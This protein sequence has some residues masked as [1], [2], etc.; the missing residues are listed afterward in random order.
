MSRS[1]K[2]SVP[3]QKY[4]ADKRNR[5]GA[6][7]IVNERIHESLERK[8]SALD[9][10][11]LGIESLPADIARLVHLEKLD[12]S[13]NRLAELPASIGQLTRLRRLDLINNRLAVVPESIGRLS[14]LERLYL[15]YN[16]LAV[17][18]ESIGRLTKLQN[19]YL[20]GNQLAKVPE[21][22]GQLSGLQR[23]SLGGNR[24]TEVPEWFGQL[25]ELQVLILH[26][27]QLTE[28][29]EWF[30][31]LA[32]LQELILG[33]NQLAALPKSIGQLAGLRVLEV[34][35]NQLASLPEE[36]RRL[37]RL[38]A[39]YLHDNPAVAGLPAEVLGPTWRQVLHDKKTPAKPDQILDY[40]FRTR[41]PVRPLNE[42]KLILLGRG[43]VGK[44]CLV[45][46]LVHDTFEPQP[47][48]EGIRIT[49]WPVQLYGDEEVRLHVWDF[50]GQEIMHA[51][52]QFFLTERSLY[53]L[54]LSGREGT[55]DLDAEYWLRIIESFG[56]ES[57]V[58]VVLNKI[59]VKPFDV[60]RRALQSKYPGIREFLLTDCN[61]RTG[62]D[63]LHAAIRREI[64]RLEDRRAKIPATWFA[65]K[66]GLS[67]TG[68]NYLTY[69]EYRK[70]CLERGET[71]PDAQDK[72]AGFLHVLGIA[73]NYRDDPRLRYHHV[74]NPHWVTAGIYALINSRLLATQ[75]G[76][77][78][79]DDIARIV[80]S[81]AAAG[82]L[83]REDYPRSMHGFLLD[84]MR[85]F[86]LCFPFPGDYSRYLVPELLDKQEP[87]EAAEFD[88]A[89]CLNFQYHYPVV[90]EGL[91]PRFTVRT[92][93]LSEG[94]PRWR[95]GVILQFEGNL[96]L[97]KADSAE[98]RVAI[99]VRGPSP[100]SRRRLLAVIRSDFD[101]IHRD[102]KRKPQE[103]VP[104]PKLPDVVV[105]YKNL[106]AFEEK[107]ISDLP[108]VAGTD[109]VI[110]K[111]PELLW[112]VDFPAARARRPGPGRICTEPEADGMTPLRLFYSHSHKDE[113]LRNQLETHLKLMQ[114]AGVITAW[115][116]RL[117]GAGEEWKDEID[118]NL[119]RADLILLLVSSDFIASDYCYDKE[120]TQALQWHDVGK[121]RV[122]PVIVRD[123]NWSKAPFA[124]LQALP[125]D[126][127]AVTLWP[128]RDCAW[129]NVAEGIERAAEELR[130]TRQ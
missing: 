32:G 52:H 33:D 16:R 14:K 26:D 38:E 54:V 116:D 74:L 112:G 110:L 11:G 92:H 8:N 68:K 40:Y 53:L 111:V 43:L 6:R 91:L 66:E 65:I 69:E 105:P 98:K 59:K 49:Q 121:T 120:M 36:L 47:M 24:F 100:D 70:F 64:D 127:K 45:N 21:S 46:R 60:N 58:I 86:E 30:G 15:G 1:R 78:H 73:L 117:I 41:G 129:R 48:T 113:D 119:E 123:V 56:A 5:E 128:D 22:V 80:D 67:R 79:F 99:S 72:L 126:G 89:A 75:K 51:T 37:E 90:P 114:R 61:D 106:R 104:V 94:Q 34:T 118:K 19:L 55:E 95:T 44:T 87:A 13:D 62:L 115:H 76:V 107:G 122:I 10:S 27:N 28:V 85:R 109:V 12:L 102:L 23:L 81:A 42:A 82:S 25:A 103:M 71:E 17:V 31:Q 2:F 124:K 9:L 125:K 88:P 96:A 3:K 50:G 93:V 130:K 77:L 97:V 108:V 57:P 84:L 83:E 29:P 20:T 7:S 101:H 39:L 4:I 63:D 35:N 18:P